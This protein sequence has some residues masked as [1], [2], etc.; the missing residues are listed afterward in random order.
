ML[1]LDYGA[2]KS[3][4]HLPGE[5]P[6]LGPTM[7]VALT[8]ATGFVG[9]YIVEHLL[10]R[11]HEVRALVREPDGAGWLR[12]RGVGLVV[13]DLEDQAALR[14]LTRGAGAVV[15][16][17]GIILELGRQTYE[18]VHVTGTRHLVNAAREAGVGR[19]VHM[20]ALGARPDASATPYHRTKAAGEEVVRTSGLPHVILRPSLIAA[21]GNEVLGT[22]VTMLRM[23][24]IMPMRISPE[25]GGAAHA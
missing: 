10:R 23:S 2:V 9:R 5:G 16:L 15:H 4:F 19:F 13:G 17:V 3:W 6:I 14:E 21:P 22:M 12:D 25:G 8:G 18:R 7:L 24:P 20:S 1:L 11:D